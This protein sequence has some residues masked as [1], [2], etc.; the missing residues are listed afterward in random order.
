MTDLK[1]S[2]LPAADAL[3]GTEL[4]A[5]VQGGTTKQATAQDIADLASGGPAGSVVVASS[6]ASSAA[7]PR[8]VLAIPGGS[9]GAQQTLEIDSY[10]SYNQNGAGNTFELD[11][12]YHN[13]NFRFS[14]IGSGGG[15]TD[16]SGYV[17]FH[18]KVQNLNAVNQQLVTAQCTYGF[19]Q[20]SGPG[21]KAVIAGQTSGGNNGPFAIDTT[22]S[23]NFR[24]DDSTAPTGIL[25][26]RATV[27]RVVP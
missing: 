23:R 3:T 25:T 24:V 1:I 19:G 26:H 2:Q 7:D 21:L 22:V 9:F 11:A 16:N 18:F 8:I 13:A 27:A 5:V 6:F 20:A 14:I 17:H 15:S 4:L 10:F 12:A